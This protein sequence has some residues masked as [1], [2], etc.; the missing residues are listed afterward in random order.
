[1][2][3]SRLAVTALLALF[4]AVLLGSCTSERSALAARNIDSSIAASEAMMLSLRDSVRGVGEEVRASR[5]RT[6]LELRASDTLDACSSPLPAPQVTRHTTDLVTIELPAD[7]KLTRNGD[8]EPM[9]KIYGYSI[10]EWTGSDR[11]RVIIQPVNNH[12][13]HAGWTGLME[14]DCNLDIGPRPAHLDIANATVEVEDRIVHVN[15]DLAPELA[16]MLV[17]HARSRERQ[18]QLLSAVHSLRVKPAW[19]V[20]E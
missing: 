2:T 14:S 11:S 6:A 3:A 9:K 1:M 4:A 19:G 12:E 8:T 16:L 20:K 17:A 10:Y 5:T 18:A 13:P 7:F 15:I